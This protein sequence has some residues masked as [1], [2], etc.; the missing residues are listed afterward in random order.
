MMLEVIER[1]EIASPDT[2][3]YKYH[4][5]NSPNPCKECGAELVSFVTQDLEEAY[6]HSLRNGV[7]MWIMKD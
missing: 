2:K 1:A 3:G 7:A 6:L 5:S 4:C